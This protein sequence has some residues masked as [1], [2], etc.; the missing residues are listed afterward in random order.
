MSKLRLEV[1]LE[2]FR[3]R[4]CM[5]QVWREGTMSVKEST[6]LLDPVPTA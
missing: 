1:F 6:K 4:S 5:S 3:H 2:D